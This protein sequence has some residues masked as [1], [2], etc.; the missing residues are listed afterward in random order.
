MGADNSPIIIKINLQKQNF[1]P[2][3]IIN[4]SFNF[5]FQKGEKKINLKSPNV[6]I[7]FPTMEYTSHWNRFRQASSNL[8]SATVNFPQ[9]L[10]VKN[11]PKIQVPFQI[12]I[13]INAKPSF[14]WP[15]D[16]MS[17][18]YRNFLRI[19]IPEVKAVGTVLI[20]IKKPS[21]PLNTPLNLVQNSQI[22][23]V[24]CTDN[25]ILNVNYN[26][27]SFPINSKIPFTFTADF[28]HAK[29][30]I[31]SLEFVLKRKIKLFQENKTLEEEIIDELQQKSVKSNMTK[32]Q[33]VNFVADLNDPQEIYQ[34]YSMG[35]LAVAK[36]LSPNNVINL[37]PNIKAVLFEC[38]YYIEVKAITDTPLISIYNSPSMIVPLDVF[39]ADNYNANF[40]INQ[41]AYQQA[42]MQ[43]SYIEKPQQQI[44]QTMQG[45]QLNK[46]QENGEFDIPSQEEVMGQQSDYSS[47]QSNDNAPPAAQD[48]G[49]DNT[50]YNYSNDIA[51]YPSL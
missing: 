33:T 39:Q 12:Q 26:T 16:N 8:G 11:N 34:K 18:S 7:S 50:S 1:Y 13:P 9:L 27:N 47:Q 40:Y 45:G 25:V 35:K 32:I 30:N 15:L 37:I 48:N 24:F 14:E 3:E 38:E 28:S 21:T 51:G 42:P 19:E 10:E 22:K 44:N 5:D 29:N 41:S 20:I 4:G 31:K 36:G 46:Q 43:Q 23:G 6:L 49:N 2:G 17:A